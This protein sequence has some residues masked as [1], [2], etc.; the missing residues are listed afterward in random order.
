MIGRTSF[1]KLTPRGFHRYALCRLP[2]G[3]VPLD[4][5]YPIREN[6]LPTTPRLKAQTLKI[7]KRKKIK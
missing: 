5:A 6:A 4:Y 1:L 3:Y 2:S 7:E